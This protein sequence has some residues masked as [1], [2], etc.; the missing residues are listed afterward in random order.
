MYMY[1]AGCTT[2]CSHAQLCTVSSNCISTVTKDLTADRDLWVSGLLPPSYEETLKTVA[3]HIYTGTH[4]PASICTYRP[5]S[6]ADMT[7]IAHGTPID[8]VLNAPLCLTGPTLLLRRDSVIQLPEWTVG[9]N[10][11]YKYTCAIEIIATVA[12]HIYI[13]LG[14]PENL[15]TKCK[16]KQVYQ[17]SGLV[18]QQSSLISLPKFTILV[19]FGWDSEKLVSFII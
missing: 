15:Q 17:C 19:N 11:K 4:L 1:V 9:D 6:A 3:T 10:L 8:S 16:C 13:Y 7:T 12:F 2:F 14:L 5:A 18:Y